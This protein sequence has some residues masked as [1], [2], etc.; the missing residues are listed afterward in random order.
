MT[1]TL[2]IATYL[3]Q[4][5]DSWWCTNV[6]RLATECWELQWMIPKQTSY[7]ILMSC[8]L[9]RVTWHTDRP[10]RWFLCPSPNFI[11]GGI[12]NTSDAS[13]P[14]HIMWPGLCKVSHMHAFLYFEAHFKSSD[15]SPP[16]HLIIKKLEKLNKIC[17]A[18]NEGINTFHINKCKTR[19]PQIL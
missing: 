11:N 16:K 13:N 15:G 6:P 18:F 1:L 4:D 14:S 7:W 12:K 19:K 3:S 8:Q 10:A 9:H 5:T 17:F 2:K